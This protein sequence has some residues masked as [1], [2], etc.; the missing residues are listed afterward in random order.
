MCYEYFKILKCNKIK[1]KGENMYFVI[2][3]CYLHVCMYI[4]ATY[5]YGWD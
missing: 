2:I 1:L 5:I 4:C 3:I